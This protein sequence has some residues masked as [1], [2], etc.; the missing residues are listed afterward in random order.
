MSIFKKIRG[1]IEAR[2]REVGL[3]NE[4]CEHLRQIGIE[5]TVLDFKS[6]EAVHHTPTGHIIYGMNNWPPLGSVK[7]E[8]RNIDL[9]EVI[10]LPQRARQRDI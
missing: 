4:L 7:V 1:K 6:P 5:A 3:I 2:T 9:V 8:G 10:R